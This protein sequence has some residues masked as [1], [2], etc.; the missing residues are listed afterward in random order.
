MLDVVSA[1]GMLTRNIW[2]QVTSEAHVRGVAI[3]TKET[4]PFSAL[5]PSQNGPYSLYLIPTREVTY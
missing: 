4:K 3:A 1:D 2:R 5:H